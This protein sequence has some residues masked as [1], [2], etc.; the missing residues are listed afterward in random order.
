MRT[1]RQSDLLET[2]SAERNRAQ[3]IAL[4]CVVGAGLLAVGFV[5]LAGLYWDARSQARELREEVA[6]LKGS[7]EASKKENDGLTVALE[8]LSHLGAKATNP[9]DDDDHDDDDTGADL[10]PSPA[11]TDAEA[12][13]K[14]KAG[15]AQSPVKNETSW[16]LQRS[17]KSCVEQENGRS[18][19]R[20]GYAFRTGK[21]GAPKDLKEAVVWF[22]RGCEAG[23]ALACNNLGM[24]HFQ[25]WGVE[26]DRSK[27]AE[28]F[29]KACAGDDKDG[30]ANLGGLYAGGLGGL[31]RDRAKALRLFS[32]GCRLGS[33]RGCWR[34]AT[35]RLKNGEKPKSVEPLLRT[36][37]SEDVAAACEKL[38][39]LGLN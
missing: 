33:P 2:L 30:C 11:G 32:K 21:I 27:A 24:S 12:T 9:A 18:C 19:N 14:A 36:A 16:S 38:E 25:G 31:V 37:C 5:Y 6:S 17:Q 26:A 10:M 29:E 13:A 15:D 28:A 1:R 35:L 20:V 4:A 3:W 23:D 7:L 39:E 22:R 34:E 8:K